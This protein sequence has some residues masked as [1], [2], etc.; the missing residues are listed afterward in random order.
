MPYTMSCER[1]ECDRE[2]ELHTYPQIATINGIDITFMAASYRCLTC[3]D[4][5]DTI[6]TLD[7]NLRRAREKM[8]E[9]G[10]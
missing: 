1:C 6:E 10:G 4:L 5:F 2:V 3:D 9:M 7:E 8:K